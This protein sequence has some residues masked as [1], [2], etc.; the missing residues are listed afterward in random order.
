MRRFFQNVFAETPMCRQLSIVL[1]FCLVPLLAFPRKVSLRKLQTTGLPVVVV[2]TEGHEEPT[3]EFLRI[4]SGY[5]G[6][7][8]RNATKVPGRVLV[9]Q[10]LDTLYDSGPWLEDV[11]GMTVKMRG[12]SS[13]FRVKHP[14]KLK[15]QK[16][17][18]MLTRGN[19]AK[20]KDKD[21]LL[22]DG[23]TLNMLTGMMVSRMMELQWTPAYKYVNLL[24]NGDYRGIYILCE[25]VKRNPRCR[26][27]VSEDQGF[28]IEKDAYWWNADLY[29]Q[30]RASQ[31]NYTFKYPDS[32]NLTDTFIDYVQGRVTD[33]ERSVADGTYDRHID[34]ASFAAWLLAHDLL[35]NADAAGSNIYVT[36]RDSTSKLEMGN[37]WDLDTNYYRYDEWATIHTW[38]D[39]PFGAM[40]ES[41]NPSFA[42]AYIAK[43]D[44]VSP[45]LFCRIEAS[46]D[47]FLITD[48]YR[49][50]ERSR[51][52]ENDSIG[53][54]FPT[55]AE[56][57]DEA[58]RWFARREE[59]LSGAMSAFA[60]HV[61]TVV[62]AVVA[63]RLPHA[64]VGRRAYRLD[65]LP[66]TSVPGTTARHPFLIKDGKKIIIK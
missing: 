52:I 56:G 60:A 48:C 8:I 28:I 36:C 2:E 21:W 34:V 38:W 66:A 44:S 17:A 57:V 23:S 4:D 45:W 29:F 14:F 31:R 13:A 3:C 19:D 7:T 27:D 54:R 33:W 30:S 61:D 26:L 9:V 51:R 15:L 58:R 65:G 53:F 37:L 24:F 10:G 18:D 16:K 6:N 55:I 35:G 49:A 22:L 32:D 43:W 46:L 62:A 11:S 39:F 63:P 42:C 59:W 50:L 12:N 1:A 64:P 25:S 40:L 41:P 5:P 47:S 20:Y